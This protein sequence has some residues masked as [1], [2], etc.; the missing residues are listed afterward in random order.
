MVGSKTQQYEVEPCINLHLV[1]T[2]LYTSQLYLSPEQ[3]SGPLATLLLKYNLE[4]PVSRQ[5]FVL[6]SIKIN[7][8]KKAPGISSQC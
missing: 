7:E 4:W 3:K 2:D 1:K 6:S 5:L 8:G